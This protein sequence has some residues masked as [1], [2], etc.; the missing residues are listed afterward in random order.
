MVA[1]TTAGSVHKT[2]STCARE[3]RKNFSAQKVG[4]TGRRASIMSTH[5]KYHGDAWRSAAKSIAVDRA[6]ALM[7]VVDLFC[8]S[9]QLGGSNVA[10]Q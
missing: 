5:G 9:V 7:H 3:I 6:T 2:D 10:N 1:R 4:R 8:G